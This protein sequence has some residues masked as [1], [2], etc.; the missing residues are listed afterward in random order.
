MLL[1]TTKTQMWI[2]RKRNWPTFA[3][4]PTRSPGVSIPSASW[5]SANASPTAAPRSCSRTPSDAVSSL[6]TGRVPNPR[7]RDQRHPQGQQTATG[8]D[9]FFSLW[10]Y[11]TP[12]PVAWLADAYFGRQVAAQPSASPVLRADV[13]C[14]DTNMIMISIASAGV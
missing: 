3:V 1:E 9:T 7:R 14:I 8:L 5:D 2:L 11:V 6:S 12:L 4:W 13:H 10:C